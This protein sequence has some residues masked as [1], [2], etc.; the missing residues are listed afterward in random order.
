MSKAAIDQEL[1]AR[2]Q[3]VLTSVEFLLLLPHENWSVETAANM[4][5]QLRR[6]ALA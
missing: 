5:M 2:G 6:K 3:R 4:I 1:A